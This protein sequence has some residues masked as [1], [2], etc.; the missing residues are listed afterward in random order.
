MPEGSARA[1]LPD[2]ADAELHLSKT[3]AL[4]RG[5]PSLMRDFSGTGVRR[6]GLRR[7]DG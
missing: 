3:A 4:G 2:L 6:S 5:D 1:Y 7:W